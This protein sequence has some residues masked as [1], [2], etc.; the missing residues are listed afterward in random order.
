V[1]SLADVGFLALI[2][3]VLKLDLML[4]FLGF[5]FLFLS[6]FKLFRDLGGFLLH[7]VEGLPDRLSVLSKL[8]ILPCK[9]GGF[10]FDTLS[11]LEKLVSALILF[12]LVV[13]ELPLS[14]LSSLSLSL[15]SSSCL[16][17]E[18]MLDILSFL[19]LL[20]NHAINLFLL[21]NKFLLSLID[22]FGCLAQLGVLFHQVGQVFLLAF[23]PE[24]PLF[25]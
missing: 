18:L 9:F 14:L 12:L 8:S 6:H 22:V 11:L 21:L 5:M 3:E 23:F 15:S 16:E 10:A 17:V 4:V 24:L 25:L 2:P 1:L 19:H 20:C 7:L 13:H